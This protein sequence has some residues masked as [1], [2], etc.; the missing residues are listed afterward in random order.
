MNGKLLFHVVDMTSA[1]LSA[2]YTV[3]SGV[4]KKWRVLISPLSL[5]AAFQTE[6]EST[7]GVTRYASLRSI[8]QYL[9]SA[10]T[11]G[12]EI[13]ALRWGLGCVN[14]CDVARWRVEF[15]KETVTLLTGRSGSRS[16]C[17]MFSECIICGVAVSRF[18]LSC[19]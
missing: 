9:R 19:A 3:P 12:L 17:W 4:N 6:A 5:L 1:L 10:K 16:V 8:D 15:P 18:P 2:E 14:I 11:A 13:A 7:L